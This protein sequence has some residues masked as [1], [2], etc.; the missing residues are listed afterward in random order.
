MTI[1][2]GFDFFVGILIFASPLAF[3]ETRSAKSDPLNFPTAQ[4]DS[5]FIEL[6]DWATRNDLHVAS[7]TNTKSFRMIVVGCAEKGECAFVHENKG[8]TRIFEPRLRRDWVLMLKPDVPPEKLRDLSC[9]LFPTPK[10]DG[11]TG[12]CTLT[13]IAKTRT[14]LVRGS[15]DVARVLGHA[16]A[17]AAKINLIRKGR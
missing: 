2:R 4:K 13:P 1:L 17:P 7:A 6:N 8:R 12:A 3:G 16:R 11:G 15:P 10:A 9:T 14:E 5:H